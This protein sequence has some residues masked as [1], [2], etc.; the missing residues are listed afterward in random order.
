MYVQVYRCV[1]ATTVS[2]PGTGRI[3]LSRWYPQVFKRNSNPTLH[4]P[5]PYSGGDMKFGFCATFLTTGITHMC[6]DFLLRK[7]ITSCQVSEG[8]DYLHRLNIIYR[9]LKPQY[10]LVVSK[11]LGVPRN[12]TLAD[13]GVSG[14]GLFPL[15]FQSFIWPF[16]KANPQT[17]RNPLT[18]GLTL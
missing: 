6:L 16:S 17:Q 7:V 3:W 10:I 9:D 13:F 15:C 4:P 5:G 8:L 18:P 11:D 12:V 14:I 2:G 1:A